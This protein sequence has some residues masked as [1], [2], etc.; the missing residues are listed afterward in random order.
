MKI[1][2]ETITLNGKCKKSGP[3]SS[4]S[5]ESNLTG[6]SS[7]TGK[8]YN[9]IVS[10]LL[11][12]DFGVGNIPGSSNN[13]NPKATLTEINNNSLDINTAKPITINPQFSLVYVDDSNE[14]VIY[15]YS[16]ISNVPQIDVKNNDEQSASYRFIPLSFD[17]MITS[18]D[19]SKSDFID[20]S[21]KS[22][23]SVGARYFIFDD[24]KLNMFVY[25]KN[26][27]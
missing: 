4:S 26:Y 9:L 2:G 10:R 6:T 22:E 17:P 15:L 25:G 11:L 7:K 16:R 12:T 23:E 20:F 8:S 24:D 21:L 27:S 18:T 14:D 13:G 5:Y 3:S 1:N 19:L